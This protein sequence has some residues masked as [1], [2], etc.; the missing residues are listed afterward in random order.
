MRDKLLLVL[1]FVLGCL[2]VINIANA[3]EQKRDLKVLQVPDSS[4]VL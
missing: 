2:L 1:T 3:L 4:I